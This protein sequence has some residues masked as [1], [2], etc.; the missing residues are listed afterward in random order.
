MRNNGDR[1]DNN[2]NRDS[3]EA[4]AEFPGG[5][6]RTLAPFVRSFVRR[7]SYSSHFV[8][9]ALLLLSSDTEALAR[10]R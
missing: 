4:T 9:A 3:D 8:A 7:D 6:P 2:N 1:R 5:F 10:A